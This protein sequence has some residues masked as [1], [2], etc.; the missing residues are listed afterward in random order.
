MTRI[1][2]NGPIEFD[3]FL[4]ARIRALYCTPRHVRRYVKRKFNKRF[5]KIGKA[6]IRQ[7]TGDL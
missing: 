5:R 7:T 2:M 1:P 6:E 4:P 3:A